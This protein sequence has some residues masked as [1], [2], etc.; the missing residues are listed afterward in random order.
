MQHQQ[1][2][3]RYLGREIILD[4][5]AFCKALAQY[6]LVKL[7]HEVFSAV[8]HCEELIDRTK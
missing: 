1:G 3:L 2:Y 8:C 6:G 4:Y 7:G 5:A